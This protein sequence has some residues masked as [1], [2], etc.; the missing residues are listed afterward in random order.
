MYRFARLLPVLAL[1]GCSTVSAEDIDGFGIV[2]SSL[3]VHIDADDYESH[4]VMLTNVPG[5]CGLIQDYWDA[6]KELTEE[7][8][9]LDDYDDYCEDMQEYYENA[10][11]AADALYHEG[12]NFVS[13]TV[14]DDEYDTEPSDEKYEVGD[15]DA[16]L[17]AGI[18]FYTESP[19]ASILD[20]WDEDED[21]EEGCGVD[22][23]DDYADY[24]A[25]EDGEFDIAAV[26]DEASLSGQLEGDLID[27]D[28]D[29]AGEIN[30]GVS[31]TWCDIKD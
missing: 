11:T 2:W 13:I 15:S 7:L 22:S 9:D 5:A 29:D 14:Y 23:E 12:S 25:L 24:W 27:D 3:W 31:A 19:Y 17:S 20:D 8:E 1:F 21:Y 4:S 18:T 10:A 28:G 30:V 16:G 6:S 26:N